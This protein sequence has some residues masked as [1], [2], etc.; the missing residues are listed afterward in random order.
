MDH[1]RAGFTSVPTYQDGTTVAALHSTVGLRVVSSTG[2]A[3]GTPSMSG[4]GTTL[5][6]FCG[7]AG[8]AAIRPQHSPPWAARSSRRLTSAVSSPR[9]PSG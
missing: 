6:V 3:V 8:I 5:R 1:E 2:G 7:R 4:A 9:A